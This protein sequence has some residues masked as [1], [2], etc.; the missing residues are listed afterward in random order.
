MTAF[1]YQRSSITSLNPYS[2]IADPESLIRESLIRESL[3]LASESL[4][5][6]SPDQESK[7][8]LSREAHQREGRR[9]ASRDY[10]SA[11]CIPRCTSWTVE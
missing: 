2:L 11:K 4:I 8:R 5:L 7:P 1:L 3:I 9:A 10:T 6:E